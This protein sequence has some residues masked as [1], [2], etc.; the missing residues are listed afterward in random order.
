M[1]Q[2][3]HLEQGAHFRGI[4][5]AAAAALDRRDLRLAGAGAGDERGGAGRDAELGEKG[6]LRHR[7]PGAGAGGARRGG[8]G[9]EVDMGGEIGLAGRRQHRMR[10]VPADRL[11]RFA[12][13]AREIAVIDEERRAAL[14]FQPGAE[15]RRER[16]RRGADLEEAPRR[17][18]AQR[19]RHQRRRGARRPIDDEAQR[20]GR[21]IERHQPLVPA[22][23]AALELPDRQRV[24][25]LVGDEEQRPIGQARDAVMPDRRVLRRAPGL[26]PRAAPGSPRPDAARSRGGT[27]GRPA[28]RA[29]R[30]P[31]AC[32]GRGR[33]RRGRPAAAVPS[34]PRCRR[35]RGR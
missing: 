10:L 4:D 12:A 9:G 34:S 11:Q 28:P 24:E 20:V 33:A 1:S 18:L 30:R 21:G 25:E 31:S 7:P 27:P 29:T 23:L 3:Q 2:R 15:R 32:R 6:A 5:Q 14:L 35:T 8:E 26:A 19:R 22:A 16:Q 13:G 17:R